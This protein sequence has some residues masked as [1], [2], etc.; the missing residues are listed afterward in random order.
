[1]QTE[2]A[3]KRPSSTAAMIGSWAAVAGWMGVIFYMSSKTGMSV[4]SWMT[5]VAHFSEYV[6]LALLLCL[7]LRVSTKLDT[8]TLLLVA[9]LVASAYGISDEFHQSFVPTRQ[10]DVMDW[11]ID[12]AGAGVAAVLFGL[13]LRLRTSKEAAG[14]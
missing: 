10:P 2:A 1:M 9:L 7:A 8:R 6:I 12:T 13:V 11:V 4:L 5:Y 14:P 3:L